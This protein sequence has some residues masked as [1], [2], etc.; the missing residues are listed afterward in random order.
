[1]LLIGS[2]TDTIIVVIIAVIAIGCIAL[3]LEGWLIGQLN[4]L[5]RILLIVAGCLL[6][7]IKPAVVVT[8]GVL[9][10]SA[11]FWHWWEHR[12]EALQEKHR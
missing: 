10:A 1:M 8:S 4:L 9:I 2:I 5:Q 7:V 3:A 11:L 6:L 12:H